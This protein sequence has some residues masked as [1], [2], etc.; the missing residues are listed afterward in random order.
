MLYLRKCAVK[1]PNRNLPAFH[2]YLA[3]AHVKLIRDERA[4]SPC[5]RDALRLTRALFTAGYRELRV[6]SKSW[7]LKITEGWTEGCCR[8]W[9]DDI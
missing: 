3:A 6:C 8:C 4:G 9:L 5:S 2:V 7:S 1:I